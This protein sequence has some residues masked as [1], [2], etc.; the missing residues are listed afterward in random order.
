MRMAIVLIAAPRLANATLV[1]ALAF[2]VTVILPARAVADPY[3]FVPQTRL[4]IT[5]VQWMPSKGEYQRWDSASGEFTVSSE[6][7]IRLPIIGSVGIANSSAT[8]LERQ[9]AER[10]KSKAGL[11]ALPDATVEVVGY[12]P[13]YVVGDV[14]TPGEKPFRPGLTVLQALSL[15]GGV[16]RPVTDSGIKGQ[17]A[18]VGELEQT[19]DEILRTAARRSRL[20]A[21]MMGEKEIKFSSEIAEGSKDGL[22]TE[23]MGQEKLIFRARRDALERQLQNLSELRNLLVSEIDTLGQKTRAMEENIRIVESELRDVKSL[24]ERGIATVSRRS[25]LERAL[26]DLKNDRLDQ[27]TA[28]MRARQGLSEATR[29]EAGLR[30]QFQTEVSTEMQQIQ[31]NHER[32]RIKEEVLKKTLVLTATSDTNNA[33]Q[34]VGTNSELS[35]TIV[36]NLKGITQELPASESTLLMPSDVVKVGVRERSRRRVNASATAAVPNL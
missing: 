28:T 31:A 21:E 30:D 7:D 22:L 8:E 4:R 3:P 10:F 12:P 36:R 32:V 19:R 1:M 23:I 16:Y 17:V 34:N 29:N 14:A 18:L 13:V 33:Q 2:I 26:A 35:F 6:G 27:I 20:Q 11:I 9:I 25:E 5:V 24:V 15:G